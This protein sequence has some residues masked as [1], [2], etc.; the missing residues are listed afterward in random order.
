[1]L[2][3]IILRAV[4]GTPPIPGEKNVGVFLNALQN[5]GNFG[6]VRRMKNEFWRDFV[7]TNVGD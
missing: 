6:H 1:M 2:D 3:E 5:A 7:G 4:M